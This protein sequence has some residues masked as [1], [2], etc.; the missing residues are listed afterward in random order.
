MCLQRRD[1]YV[2]IH[3]LFNDAG[4]GTQHG[5]SHPFRHTF[6]THRLRDGTDLA[7]LRDLLGHSDISVTSRYLG[8]SPQRAE[9]VAALA[10]LPGPGGSPDERQGQLH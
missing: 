2:A 3:S 6:A 9:A 5:T 4:I 1:C 10:H 8:A 7:T